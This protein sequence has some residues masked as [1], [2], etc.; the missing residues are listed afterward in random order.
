MLPSFALPTMT[1]LRTAHST[2]EASIP[3]IY[4]LRSRAPERFGYTSQCGPRVGINST[5]CIWGRTPD[6]VSDTVENDADEKIG[7][8]NNYTSRD[9]TSW[10]DRS[11]MG[12]L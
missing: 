4:V 10:S 5:S 6:S 1:E 9:L 3:T 7:C 8:Y 12:T 11:D 2:L